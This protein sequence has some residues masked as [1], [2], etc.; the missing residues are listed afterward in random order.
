MLSVLQ[1]ADGSHLLVNRGWV[2]FTGY[3]ERLPEVTLAGDSAQRLAGR[4]STLPI[5]GTAS[6]QYVNRTPSLG[7]E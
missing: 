2:P 3:R 1:L 6:G 5:A 7:M 4:L